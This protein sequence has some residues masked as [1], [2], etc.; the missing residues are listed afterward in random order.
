[1]TRSILFPS[2][3]AACVL[4]AVTTA[5]AQSKP[6]G[7]T[8]RSVAYPTV[9][10]DDDDVRKNL[11]EAMALL[12]RGDASDEARDAAIKMLGKALEGLDS[13]NKTMRGKLLLE[14]GKAVR[15]GGNTAFGGIR[16]GAAQ[17]PQGE[18]ENKS[19]K[20]SKGGSFTF[21]VADD[22]D[23]VVRHI[24]GKKGEKGE[25]AAVSR[26]LTFLRA[27]QSDDGATYAAPLAIAGGVEGGDAIALLRSLGQGDEGDAKA[28]KIGRTLAEVTRALAMPQ[29]A[30]NADGRDDAP[31]RLR[32]LLQGDDGDRKD[33]P[34]IRRGNVRTA[35][36]DRDLGDFLARVDVPEG[37]DG[38]DDDI[39]AAIRGVSKELR[40][41][42]KLMERAH[43]HLGDAGAGRGNDGSRRVR[44]HLQD[45]KQGAEVRRYRRVEK[46]DSDDD[47]DSK[48]PSVSF[49]WSTKAPEHFTFKQ[50]GQANGRWTARAP[51]A[52]K[53]DRQGATEDQVLYWTQNAPKAVKKKVGRDGDAQYW[54]E[55][56]PENVRQAPVLQWA[57]PKEAKGDWLP[58]RIAPKA[59]KKKVQ[60]DSESGSTI[61]YVPEVKVEAP[62][63]KKKAPKAQAAPKLIRA[64]YIK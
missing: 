62:P 36:K 32:A 33:D 55:Y 54:I 25:K 5:S 59:V 51:K 11:S 8:K 34:I 60:G 15:L 46:E 44:L 53:T 1:M 37:N 27:A 56:Q 58:T 16:K 13:Q 41:I 19:K 20:D 26:G 10:V 63:A 22:A 30:G 31:V 9:I 3:L 35:R 61:W 6:T 7:K 38:D 42:R 47:G 43:D 50:G 12:R 48:K 45:P 49:G 24:Q 2:L 29:G 23:A 18:R 39:V 64:R 17:Q 40:A 21:R 52:A 28:R 14:D 57:T 4:A